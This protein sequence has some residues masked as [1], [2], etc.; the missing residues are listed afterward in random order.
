MVLVKT[1][2]E[3]PWKCGKFSPLFSPKQR[4]SCHKYTNCGT[5]KLSCDNCL[6]SFR[7]S[8]TL[9]QYQSPCKEVK[10]LHE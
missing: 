4:L 2:A 8:Y 1:K 10:R 5:K 3:K 9:A 7:C 6:K